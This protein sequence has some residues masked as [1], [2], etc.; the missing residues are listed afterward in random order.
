MDDELE[1]CDLC[2]QIAS[3]QVDLSPT[4]EPPGFIYKS[5]SMLYGTQ[6]KAPYFEQK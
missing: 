3:M 6:T 4:L 5:T 2:L 1:E